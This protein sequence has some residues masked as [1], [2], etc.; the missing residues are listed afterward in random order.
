[1]RD[2][3][4]TTTDP[5]SLG[6]TPHVPPR[7]PVALAVALAAA[8]S[9][10]AC[11]GGY[12]SVEAGWSGGEV[13]AETGRIALITLRVHNSFG[14]PDVPL[15][16]TGQFVEYEGISALAVRHALDMW[17]HDDVPQSGA[18]RLRERVAPAVPREPFFTHIALL[19]AGELSLEGPLGGVT[20][21]PRRLPSVLPYLSG[22]TYGTDANDH[23]GHVDD[24]LVAIWA[25]GSEAVPAFDLEVR[26]PAPVRIAALNDATPGSATALELPFAD[27]LSVA[28]SPAEGGGE[29]FL[30]FVSDSPGATVELRC[31][32]DES[33]RLRLGPDLIAALGDEGRAPSAL[34]VT[35]TRLRSASLELPGFEA[36]EV[37]AIAEH[38]VLLY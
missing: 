12:P 38:S 36:A 3:R 6:G 34:R 35:A 9:G 23:L 20:L 2:S 17:G 16:V 25:S 19:G 14:L 28:W 26:L 10:A 30:D 15:E 8:L 31:A 32:G 11:E 1:M 29:V 33:G 37:L 24:E 5:E 22:V 13:D 21:Y 18:C 7:R 27:G 4:T